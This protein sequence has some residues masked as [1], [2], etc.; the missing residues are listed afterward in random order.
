MRQIKQIKKYDPQIICFSALT[1]VHQ[2]IYKLA[3]LIKKEIKSN[4]ILLKIV[5]EG[6]YKTATI[7]AHTRWASVGKI[8]IPNC[9]P[10]D[11]TGQDGSKDFPLVLCCMNGDIYNYKSIIE[12]KERYTRILQN[13]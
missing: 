1:G 3:S 10:I 8:N 7:V 2:S 4:Q 6:I 9:H 13:D 5:S 12:E 11:N